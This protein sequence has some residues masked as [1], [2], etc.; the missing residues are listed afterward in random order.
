M[1][2]QKPTY[3]E[4]KDTNGE[5][6]EVDGWYTAKNG[7]YIPNQGIHLGGSKNVYFKGKVKHKHM[8]VEAKGWKKIF[9]YLSILL[10]LGGMASVFLGIMGVIDFFV[11][12]ILFFVVIV[13]LFGIAALMFL[14]K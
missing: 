7:D 3:N 9:Y 1:S 14:T 6:V 11:A 2:E 13:A 10:L 8:E 5:W 4:V 12:I